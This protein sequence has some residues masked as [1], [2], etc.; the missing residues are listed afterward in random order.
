MSSQALRQHPFW[1][2]VPLELIAVALG[3]LL[4]ALAPL[5]GLDQALYA[6]FLRVT[7]KSAPAARVA[8]VLVGPELVRQSDCAH[9]LPELVRH[10]HAESSL[11]LPPLDALCSNGDPRGLL[12]DAEIRRD[13]ASRVLG[14]AP[15]GDKAV[16]LVRNEWVAPRPWA[17]VPAV[18][19]ADL[20]SGRVPSAMLKGRVVLF[21]LEQAQG[22]RR[23]G[24]VGP[25]AA[26]VGAALASAL[27]DRPRRAA[28]TWLAV[29][30]GSVLLAEIAVRRRRPGSRLAPAWLVPATVFALCME[31]VLAGFGFGYL[32]PLASLASVT[33]LFVA[34]TELPALVAGRRARV[35][36]SRM[37]G[38]AQSVAAHAAYLSDQDFWTRM[39]RRVEQAHAADGV[40]IAELPPFSWRLHIWPNGDLSESIIRERRRD[41]R[42]TPFVD[43]AGSRRAHIVDGLLVMNGTPCVFAPLEASGELEGYLILI[44]KPAAHAFVERPTATERLADEVALLIRNRR[45]E[46]LRADA[47]RRPG[48]MLV[49]NPAKWSENLLE[50]AR[51]ASEG[52]ELLSELFRSAPVGLLYADAFGDVRMLGD[53][54]VES[55]HRFG[56][57]F[58]EAKAAGAIPPGTVSLSKLLADIARIAGRPPTSLSDITAAG[59]SLELELESG[60]EMLELVLRRLEVGGEPIGY[61]ATLVAI[62]RAAAAGVSPEAIQRMP[63]R[64]DPLTVFS[65]AELVSDTVDAVARDIQVKLRFQT[66]RE[67]GHVI[68]HRRELG[69]ALAA[70]MLDIARSQPAGSG[71]V[72]TVRERGQ[73]VELTLIDLKLGVPESAMQRT[74]LAPSVPPPGL[75]PLARFVRA[76]EESHGRVRVKGE[77]SWG[78]KLSVGLVRARPRVQPGALGRILRFS[79]APVSK[80]RT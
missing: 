58:T 55:L 25:F 50:Q 52:L 43:D 14:F 75:E 53:E 62:D 64:G 36:A 69:E 33:G 32:L 18:S 28:P 11:L 78:V 6:R 24:A 1:D 68:G 23:E 45:L 67:T 70:F 27:E 48:G 42:R 34:L 31:T 12:R 59:V 7:G 4:L 39:A 19:L 29:L 21:G 72:L 60:Q 15:R 9:A 37:L 80:R 44:G 73:W 13:S 56:I 17:S 77:Q 65:L 47:W 2:L 76:V 10:A 57:A 3:A 46:R 40:L 51:S 63:E 49:E 26:E 16:L 38:E 54:F 22:G 8:V 71:P 41:V 35:G 79:E 30:A 61:L 66:P 5:D 20:D 74:V